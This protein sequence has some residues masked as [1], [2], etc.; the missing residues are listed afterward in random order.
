MT[1][2]DI[3][4][5]LCASAADWLAGR[6]TLSRLHGEIGQVHLVDR[7]RWREM[8]EMGWLSLALP[9]ALDGSGLGLPAAAALAEV[10]GHALLPEPFVAA[11]V[12]PAALIAAMADGEA[13]AALAAEL[14]GGE[15]VLTLAW[16]AQ[17]HQIQPA[18][19]ATLSGQKLNGK[20]AFVP[21]VEDDGVLLV[22]AADE[23]GMPVIVAVAANAPGVSIERTAAGNHG[24]MA[25]LSFDNA[26]IRFGAPL[27]TGDAATAALA[28][29]LEKGRVAIAGQLVGLANAAKSIT[30]DYVAQRK[31]FERTLGSFQTVQHRLVDSHMA[32][33]MAGACFRHAAEVAESDPARLATEA[34]AAK[35]RAADTAMQVCKTAVQLHGGIGFT[36][37]ADIGLFLRDAAHLSAW[38]GSPTLLRR[39]FLATQGAKENCH[40]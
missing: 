13:R 28:D 26:L 23:A 27:L 34:A 31:Q 5:M 40:V 20:L 33:M 29:A 16:Q 9:E 36:E 17:V 19:G 25:Q 14:A 4:S 39:R 8:A 38:L 6:H 21:A 35:A 22:S 24:S 1:K 15:R 18:L 10:F 30:V 11:A 32:L 2:D 7:A 12:M 37:E 3:S